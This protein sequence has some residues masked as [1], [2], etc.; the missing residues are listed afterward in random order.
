MSQGTDAIP[1][2]VTKV[3]AARSFLLFAT[4]LAGL[5]GYGWRQKKLAA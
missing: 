2:L 5:L 1:S 3:P 4:G